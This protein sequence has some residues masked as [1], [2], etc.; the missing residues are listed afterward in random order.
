MAA[1]RIADV[2][3]AIQAGEAGALRDLLAGDPARAN[4][5][6]EWGKNGEI[7]THP[8]HYVSDMLFDGTLKRGSEIPLVE[9][10]LEA[11]ADPNHQ[12]ANGE[13]PLIGAASL[14]AA[15]VGLRLLDAGARPDSRGLWKETALHWAS[16]LGLDR[17]VARLIQMG[18]DLNLPDTRY[19]APPVG[20]AI[21]GHFSSPP[22]GHEVN[23]AEVVRLL[24]SAGAKVKPEWLADEK[25]RSDPAMLAALSS[26]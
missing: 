12:A 26:N 3:S 6:I 14:N 7:R 2:K 23:H 20:W 9:A 4:Q 10:L 24:V 22:G 5:L 13:T 18:V 25:V 1:N 11:G 21:H 15:D 8:L 16:M 19:E 17:L